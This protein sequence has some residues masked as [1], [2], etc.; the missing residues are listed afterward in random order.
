MK[1]H[2][3]RLPKFLATT[4]LLVAS[5]FLAPFLH[6]TSDIWDGDTDGNWT[7][8]G[9]WAGGN[10]PG[11]PGGSNSDSATF[12]ANLTQTVTVDAARRLGRVALSNGNYTFNNASPTG[13]LTLGTFANAIG[14]SGAPIQ[15]HT[16]NTNVSLFGTGSF[17]FLNDGGA[18]SFLGINGNVTSLTTSGVATLNVGGSRNGEIDGVISGSTGGTFNLTKNGN[19]V[20][21]FKGNNTYNGTTAVNAG[22][23]LIN[24]DQSSATGA[25]SVV[26][27]TLGGNGTIGGAVSVAANAILAPGTTTDSTTTLS[28]ATKN[29]TMLD[30]NS[31]IAMDITGTTVGSFDRIAGVDTF[32]LNGDITLTLSGSYTV[33][34]SWDLFDFNAK[35]DGTNFDSITLAG[36]YVG[37]L[38]RS[39]DIWTNSDIGGN[40]WEFNQATGILT[41]VPEPH[42]T[43]MLLGGVGVAFLIARRRSAGRI[44]R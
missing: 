33:G 43:T 42:T 35:A 1:T 7:T 25:V 23:L 6:A 22:T 10:V 5:S 12:S 44:A 16:F 26:A 21:T 39:G 11:T 13:S 14:I 38:T 4:A 31:K 17:G 24:G 28:L 37:T 41:V 30:V 19:G 18:G 3:S 32:T 40:S 34:S 29:L 9:N 8:T 36:S 2:T 27:G 20:W 15:N